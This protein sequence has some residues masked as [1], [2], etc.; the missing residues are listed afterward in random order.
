MPMLTI[1]YTL[2][3]FDFPL[4]DGTYTPRQLHQAGL[5]V[6]HGEEQTYQ[7]RWPGGMTAPANPVY[8]HASK[9]QRGRTRERTAARAAGILEG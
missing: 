4:A 2:I 3:W 8:G 7:L 9:R 6:Y 5:K 1:P